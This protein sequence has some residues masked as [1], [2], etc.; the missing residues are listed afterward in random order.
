MDESQAFDVR[1]GLGPHHRQAAAALYAEAFEAKLRPLLGPRHRI[2][3]VVEAAL[4]PAFA[5]SAVSQRGTLLGVAGYKTA[6]GA[7]TK[8]SLGVMCREYGRVSGTV[9]GVL[10]SLLERAAEPGVLVMDGI[11]VDA[12]ARGKGVGSALLRAVCEKAAT[13][14]LG[15]VRL[16]VIDTNSKARA[17]YERH[18]FIA[19]PTTHLG[20]LRHLFGFAAATTMRKAI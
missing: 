3:S 10:V 12:T 5:L 9:R 13:L 6:A 4:D 19:G 1:N 7:F 15:A 16:D 18:G 17:L 8:G 11:A 14:G 2:A 20:P